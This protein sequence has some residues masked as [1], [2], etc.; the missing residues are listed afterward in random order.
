M[1]RKDEQNNL[2]KGKENEQNTVST[3]T[4]LLFS[5]P[6]GINAEASNYMASSIDRLKDFDS[7]KQN[8][9]LKYSEEIINEFCALLPEFPKKN[10]K[11]VKTFAARKRH[12]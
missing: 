9:W 6:P 12:Y 11:Y 5:K 4:N 1:K 7:S 3:N 8:L 10:P 2:T